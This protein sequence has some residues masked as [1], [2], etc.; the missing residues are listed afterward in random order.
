MESVYRLKLVNRII[1][2]Q[3]TLPEIAMPDEHASGRAQTA[4]N[5][6]GS[7]RM[8]AWIS[9]FLHRRLDGDGAGWWDWRRCS[10]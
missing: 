10:C 6:D 5:G 9:L 1:S 4:K 7:L 8:D 2:P 3:Q